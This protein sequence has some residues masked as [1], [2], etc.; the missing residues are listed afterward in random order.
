VIPST[1]S[2]RTVIATAAILLAVVT[3]TVILARRGESIGPASPPVWL[4]PVPAVGAKASA[5]LAQPRPTATWPGATGLSGANGDPRLDTASVQSFCTARGRSCPIAHTYTDRRTYRS[6]T[7][8]SGWMFNNYAD[9]PGALVISQALTPDNRPQDLAGCA[10]GDFDANW[11]AFGFLMVQQSRADSIVRLGWEFNGKFMAWNGAD[12]D[13][14]IACYRR[15]ADNIRSANPAVVLDWTINAHN[16]P[17]TICRGVSTNC[18]PG[19]DYVDII[20]IDN[21]D[22]YP[23]SRTKAQFDATA[24][25]PEGLN[26]LLRFAKQ[27]GKPFSVGEWGVV[28]TG[29][30]GAENPEFVRWMHQW[31][32]EHAADLAYEAYFTDCTAGGVQSSLYRPDAACRPNP[33]SAAVYRQLW[34]K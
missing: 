11:Q 8:D 12:P 10:R 23:A 1:I 7:V 3:A 15:A 27:H 26:W 34:S 30:A 19:D 32:I 29:D 4:S 24:D 28:P 13:T 33:G 25:A 14:W 21:Y 31:F 9:F 18:Y 16:T 6:M 22:H 20:G 17:A 2:R 5:L